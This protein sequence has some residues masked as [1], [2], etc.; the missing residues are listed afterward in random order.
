[1][2]SL[3]TLGHFPHVDFKLMKWYDWC[4][5]FMSA[6][7]LTL[8]IVELLVMLYMDEFLYQRLKYCHE[9]GKEFNWRAQAL[10][11]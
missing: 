6:V 5:V 10:Y 9:Q 2:M 11:R 8:F 7:F 1:M 4:S 3:R